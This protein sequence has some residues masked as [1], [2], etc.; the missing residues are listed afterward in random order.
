MG[1]KNQDHQKR[2]AP[3]RQRIQYANVTNASL[4]IKQKS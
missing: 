4:L 2:T 1:V 3:C